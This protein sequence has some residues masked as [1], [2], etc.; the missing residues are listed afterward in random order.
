MIAL[1]LRDNKVNAFYIAWG[2]IT[3]YDL[4][5]GDISH[6][7]WN[8]SFLTIVAFV[9]WESHV[10][11]VMPMHSQWVSLTQEFYE[12]LSYEELGSCS[13]IWLV[14]KKD[15]TVSKLFEIFSELDINVSHYV[16]FGVVHSILN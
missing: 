9:T 16:L 4:S 13:V 8:D 1:L 2:T 15:K 11:E 6:I 7:F 14:I 10:V 3:S 12:I 5:G